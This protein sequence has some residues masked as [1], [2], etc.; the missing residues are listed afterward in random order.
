MAFL[1]VVESGT[2]FTGTIASS[3]GSCQWLYNV[4]RAFAPLVTMLR[5]TAILVQLHSSSDDYRQAGAKCLCF[6]I[7]LVPFARPSASLGRTD[8]HAVL[9]RNGQRGT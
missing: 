3:R 2:V 9:R 1:S 6:H 7:S 5:A 4:R 8:G